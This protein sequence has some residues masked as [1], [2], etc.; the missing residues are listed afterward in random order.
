M[1][2]HH[3][4]PFGKY[5]K[6]TIENTQTGDCLCLVPQR[7]AC[8]LQLTLGGQNILDGYHEPHEL[9]LLAWSKNIVLFPFP[10]R[11][12][13][14][15]YTFDGVDYQYPINNAATQNAIH[16]HGKDVEMQVKNVFTDSDSASITCRY[17]N[18]GQDNPFPFP[19][20]FEVTFSLLKPHHLRVKM[21]LRNDGHTA[22][23]AGL[24]WHPY[25]S[26]TDD[27]A[28]LTLQMPACERIEIDQRM[29][30]TGT[31]TTYTAFA[32]P[33]KIGNTVL[34][35]GFFIAQNEAKQ[36]EI[37][38][39]APQGTLHYWQQMGVGKFNFVQIF[40]PPHR[41][42]IALEPMTCN[43]DAFNSGDGLVVLLPTEC[44]E[45][46]FGMGWEPTPNA[47]E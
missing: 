10:N 3:V 17:Q 14:G 4:A 1:F 22:M 8:V 28:D 12:K 46:T 42:C 11:L 45:A 13:D 27:V 31:K 33:T 9:E 24:G 16:G 6:H 18:E 30:P 35:N 21:S 37:S 7:G 15:K 38:L 44:L 34:D 40:T 41:T 29:L 19:H 25:V 2:H 36:A 47:V 5:Q 39:V 23:P 20:S 43:I 32:Q 26:L